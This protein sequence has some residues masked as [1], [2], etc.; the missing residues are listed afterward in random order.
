MLGT[1]W[2]SALSSGAG[3]AALAIACGGEPFT[4]GLPVED[5][6]ATDVAVDVAL[7][8]GT[9]DASD[10][11]SEA[12][13]ADVHDAAVA[14]APL[15]L[16][17]PAR[18]SVADGLPAHCGGACA[19]AVP[20]GWTGPFE[21]YAG[22]SPSPMCGAAFA[23]PTLDANAGLVAPPAACACTCD[24]AKGVQCSAPTTTFYPSSTT[25]P[26]T[27]CATVSL[28][29]RACTTVDVTT[30]CL[31]GVGGAFVSVPAPAPSLGSCTP[32]ATVA[33][34]SPAWATNVRACGVSVAPARTDCPAGNVCL[35]VPSS[36]FQASACIEQAGDVAC[37][38]TAYTAK[39]V[40]Y[41]GV[42]DTRTCST[43]SC[44]PV[45]GASCT[46]SITQFQSVDGGCNTA[47]TTYNLPLA[48]APIQQ[49]SDLLL[50]LTASGGAC[51]AS[52]SAPTGSATPAKPMTFCCA[53]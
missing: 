25:C 7:E 19:P 1:R 15:R 11:L 38:L 48:C 18:D 53:P 49:P 34:P 22:S 5:A 42:D 21:L 10:D 43:C 9:E 51:K 47:Q 8:V 24:V 44:G 17:A 28:M 26:L 39:Y 35:P 33:S 30:Q 23:G 20:G 29:D 14:D 52:P 16:D 3:A 37:P 27:S 2:F 6:T 36:P 45:L 4:L 46:G 40:Y 12:S 31:L 41:G 13:T 50:T 32:V